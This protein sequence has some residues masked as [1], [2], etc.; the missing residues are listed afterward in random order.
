M[1][2]RTDPGRLSRRAMLRGAVAVGGAGALLSLLAGC[3]QA[4]AK[5]AEPTKPAAA[6]AEPT[7]PAAAPAAT[8]AP[9]APA[10][11]PPAAAPKPAG[12]GQVTVRVHM[13]TGSEAKFFDERL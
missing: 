5:P 7:K 3:G 10:T 2:A 11:A 1:A 6:A 4:P 13:R 9:S 8:T 12:Q